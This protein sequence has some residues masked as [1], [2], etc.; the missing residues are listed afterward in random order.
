MELERPML[1]IT[2]MNIEG[3]HRMVLTSRPVRRITL[4]LWDA[5]T[6]RPLGEPLQGHTG[7]VYSLSFSPDG[8]RIASGSEDNTATVGRSDGT[9]IG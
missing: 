6:G 9:A 7:M 2:R 3:F 8:A 4:R 5:A 1:A